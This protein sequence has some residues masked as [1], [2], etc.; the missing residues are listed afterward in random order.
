MAYE[1]LL[2]SLAEGA[3]RITLNRPQ[4]RNALSRTMRQ[5]SRPCSRRPRPMRPHGSSCRPGPGTVP[6][7]RERTSRAVWAIGGT[8]LQARE[9][10]GGL[11]HPRGVHAGA[12]A[13]DRAGPRLRAAG[14]LR[15]GDGCDLVGAADD[16]VFGLSEIKV[17]L[18]PLMVMAPIRRSVG[19]DC[20]LLMILSGD[21]VHAAEALQTSPVSRVVPRADLARETTA[22]AVWLAG[23]SPSA[24]ALAKE[25]VYTSQDME[26]GT[27][28][29]CLREFITLAGL[30]DDAKE[31][32]AA[33]FA[34][35][36]PEW[37][38]R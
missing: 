22:L 15:A 14:R 23:L 18:L 2:I 38:G 20:W 12:H 32:I 35:R 4:A 25:T 31:G 8:T 24:V 9:S 5:E 27:S 3:A 16:A 1:T 19:R 7:A 10:L 34:R 6:S 36:A 33:F 21:P 30:S 13:G 26:Y 11:A 28:L 29:R 37:K 17:G